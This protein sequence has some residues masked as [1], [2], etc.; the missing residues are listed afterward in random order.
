MLSLKLGYSATRGQHPLT[1]KWPVERPLGA[2]GPGQPQR[3]GGESP[4]HRGAWRLVLRSSHLW[5][6]AV[7]NDVVVVNGKT[8]LFISKL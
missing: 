2:G 8:V 7:L 4:W 5:C 6:A 3:P 1:S